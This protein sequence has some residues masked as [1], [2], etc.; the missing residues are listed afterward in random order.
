[1]PESGIDLFIYSF[2]VDML[3]AFNVLILLPRLQDLTDFKRDLSL[4]TSRLG[5]AQDCL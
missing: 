3:I 1:M 2:W 5:T 4:L